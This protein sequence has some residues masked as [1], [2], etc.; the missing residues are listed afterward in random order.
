M[1]NVSN[2]DYVIPLYTANGRIV[3]Y[4]L[5]SAAN[6]GSYTIPVITADRQFAGMDVTPMRHQNDIGFPGTTVDRQIAA[7]MGKGRD[8][9]LVVAGFDVTLGATTPT[10]DLDYNE[11][12]FFLGDI[13]TSDTVFEL[14]QTDMD[15]L[16]KKI[17][18]IAI[19]ETTGKMRLRIKQ[20]N[21]ATAIEQQFRING[22][23]VLPLDFYDGY[24]DFINVNV[25]DILLCEARINWA[26]TI[27]N[28][29]NSGQWVVHSLTGKKVVCAVVGGAYHPQQTLP[30]QIKVTFTN[31]GGAASVYN[32]THI[33]DKKTVSGGQYYT[34][35]GSGAIV[36]YYEP[37][38]ITDFPV[39]STAYSGAEN[40][41][42]LYMWHCNIAAT[43]FSATF[44]GPQNEPYNPYMAYTNTILYR[45]ASNPSANATC[46]IE[47]V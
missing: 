21:Y 27:T 20:N 39:P 38:W 31:L 7:L 18:Q 33:L 8:F 9:S 42:F 24:D 25:G 23:I 12:P 47:P 35:S 17:Y 14:T 1:T 6:S 30:D 40:L 37:K 3:A 29:I 45:W 36:T 11:S 2:G 10:G 44:V 28:L 41:A 13:D 19:K 34:A 46:L 15:D 32:G 5:V 22:N 16:N 26:G 4:K 43:G